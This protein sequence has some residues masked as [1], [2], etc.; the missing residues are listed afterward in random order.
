LPLPVAN[1]LLECCARKADAPSPRIQPYFNPR[2]NDVI[3]LLLEGLGNRQ[4]ADKL[5]ISLHSA[6]RHVSAVLS[7]T[8]SP[9][10]AHFVARMLRDDVHFAVN[11]RHHAAGV[12]GRRY[13][14]DPG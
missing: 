9:S 14:T 7:K 2:E 10:R 13:G 11:N 4:I 12:H 1:Y 6:K 5:G 8:N 3:D